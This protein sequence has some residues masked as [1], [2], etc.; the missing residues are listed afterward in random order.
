MKKT[1]TFEFKSSY[2]GGLAKV[3]QR[4]QYGFVN[5]RGRVIVP[6]RFAALL[7]FS[8][9]LAGACL[10]GKHWGFI[11]KQG[12][13]KIKPAF[14][15]VDDFY[16]GRAP[17]MTK[18]RWGLIDKKGQWILKPEYRDLGWD[19]SLGLFFAQKG[20]RYG[21]L[22][23]NLQLLAG[24]WF[25]AVADSH[26]Q[27][28]GFVRVVNGNQEG[29]LY[30]DGKLK[31]TG[32]TWQAKLMR[33]PAPSKTNQKKSDPS[34]FPKNGVSALTRPDDVLRLMRRA[35]FENEETYGAV[36][37]WMNNYNARV[38]GVGRDILE[39]EFR[40]L[41][42]DLGPLV[43]DIHQQGADDHFASQIEDDLR[44]TGR[45]FFWWD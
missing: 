6:V 18:K 24:R 41:P 11:D 37:R 36:K 20:P 23:E 34:L 40:K 25:D 39:V 22:D 19:P 16:K 32:L 1:K 26:F 42:A 33:Q 10:D 3:M 38:L 4:G 29:R 31:W 44:R 35:G 17:A 12:R 15:D 9:G 28:D 14:E 45:I 8:E 7:E 13:W 30:P 2:S 27:N 43:E 5:R 21:Y